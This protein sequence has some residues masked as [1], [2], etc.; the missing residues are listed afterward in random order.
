MWLPL[1]C[2]GNP[3]HTVVSPH[4]HAL[5]CR[6]LS[7]TGGSWPKGSLEAHETR[8]G[9]LCS[10]SMF[11]F[12]RLRES[13]DKLRGPQLDEQ[14]GEAMSAPQQVPP[15]VVMK[16][17]KELQADV[18]KCATVAFML[19]PSQ[20]GASP[21]LLFHCLTWGRVITRA[22]EVCLHQ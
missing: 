18:K 14:V 6:Q 8:V 21:D 19:A 13:L 4:A 5:G 20:Y 12:H 3:A 1:R 10:D 9:M 16:A 7:G 22:C 17:R 11:Y 15:D 2:H